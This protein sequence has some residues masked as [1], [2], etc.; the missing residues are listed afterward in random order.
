MQL[1]CASGPLIQLEEVFL[2]KRLLLTEPFTTVVEEVPVPEPKPGEALI[3]VECV[4]VCGTDV[5]SWMGRHAFTTYPRVMGHE[6]SG[7]VVKLAGDPAPCCAA[8]GR[9]QAAPAP[10]ASRAAGPTAPSIREGDVVVV[11]PYAACG[12]CYPCSIGRYNCCQNLQVMGVHRDGAMQEYICVPVSMLHKAP[13][14]RS[15]VELSFVE[16]AGIGMHA[17]GRSRLQAGD[18]AAV[19]GAG[20]IGL[21][22][23][24][25]LKAR[26]AKVIA[27][28][29]KE[30]RL[31][32]ARKLGADI[33]VN[34]TTD[35]PVKASLEFT[36]GV[37]APVVFEVVGAVPTINLALQLVSY[38]GQIVLVGVCPDE[39]C[40][41]PELLNKRELDILGSRNS[42]GVFP[43]VL[44][45]VGKGALSTEA[46]VSRK[47]TVDE[48]DQTMKDVTSGSR[49]EIKIVVQF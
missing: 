5:R 45:L 40:L 39:L 28:D 29:V 34:S 32:L 24:Q 41:H 18:T 9:C 7:T 38:A 36:G 23:I 48:F 15:F 17:I 30:S 3:R 10:A 26:G 33:T 8:S 13:Q 27:V 42:R 25:I 46:L 12:K 1:L 47:I 44:E 31:D 20:N 21:L 35:D 2:T 19:I 22:M 37:G 49:D 6:V 43:G 16:P 14:N 11:E 4:G